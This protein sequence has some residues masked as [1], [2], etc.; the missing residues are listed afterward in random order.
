MTSAQAS[1]SGLSNL[2]GPPAVQLIQR[3]YLLL[4]DRL[5]RA[6]RAHNPKKQHY[7]PAIKLALFLLGIGCALLPPKG[8]EFNPIEL[9]NGWIQRAVA[10][11]LPPDG[12]RDSYGRLVR[13]PRTKAEC[14]QALN[15]AL[16]DLKQRPA[17][18]RHWYHRRA[19][20]SDAFKRWQHHEVAKKVATARAALGDKAQVWMYEQAFAATNV[21]IHA[22]DYT[23]TAVRAAQAPSAGAGAAA[24]G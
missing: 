1:P 7:N 8:A 10:R 11:W 5:G 24:A 23:P 15:E 12:A 17:L 13:G 18:F 3:G 2:G 14:L 19:L 21:N 22:K 16:E 20:G 6:G 4:W 9:F